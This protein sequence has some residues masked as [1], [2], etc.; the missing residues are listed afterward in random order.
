M[1]LLSLSVPE[2]DDAISIHLADGGAIRLAMGRFQEPS[3]A[4][5]HAGA[6]D[7]LAGALDHHDGD[8]PILL[9]GI[10]NHRVDD[11]LGILES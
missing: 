2:V 1:P 10:F 6:G 9:A 8:A 7:Q 11:P 4:A 5:V 3:G